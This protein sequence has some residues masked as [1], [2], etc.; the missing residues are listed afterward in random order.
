[1]DE[2]AKWCEKTSIPHTRSISLDVAVLEAHRTAQAN[3]GQPGGAGT[4]LLSPACASWDQFRSYE[5]R[6]EVFARL[7]NSLDEDVS[8]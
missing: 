8:V 4:V 6:G 1:M 3:R 7:V 5:H 2:F